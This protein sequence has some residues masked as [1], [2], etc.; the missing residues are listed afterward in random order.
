[1]RGIWNIRF[2]WVY[3][4]NIENLISLY[5]K[6]L[7][8]KSKNDWDYRAVKIDWKSYMVTYFKRKFNI[9]LFDI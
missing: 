6:S 4:S 5:M 8:I 3:E 7:K 9:T 2:L 1:M